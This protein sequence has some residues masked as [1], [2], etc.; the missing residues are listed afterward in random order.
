MSSSAC[1][2][3]PAS[4]APLRPAQAT[5]SSQP[6]RSAYDAGFEAGRAAAVAEALAQH[7]AALGALHE[8]AV[9]LR[10]AARRLGAARAEAV[11]L[12]VHDAMALALAVVEELVGAVPLG[13]D[14]RRLEEALALAPD[15]E[16]AVV[17]LHPEDVGTA[18]SLPLEA[19]V[20]ADESVE[21]GG[22]VVEVGP[23][24]IDAQRG[25]ALERLRALL[26]TGGNS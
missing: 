21:R 10:R 16:L 1:L 11:K 13:L 24:R 20:V 18:I 25:P 2:V 15:D 26:L 22:C 3:D 7:E 4:V 6:G 17:R 5:S 19:K 23:T 14:A 8:A 12:G 9:A